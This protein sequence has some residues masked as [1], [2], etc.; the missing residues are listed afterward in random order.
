MMDYIWTRV[1]TLLSPVAER[2]PTVNT[3]RLAENTRLTFGS[4][5]VHGEYLPVDND[6]WSVHSVLGV[7]LREPS[8]DYYKT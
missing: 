2:L 5:S 4:W 7:C 6:Q 8:V 3:K 1:L